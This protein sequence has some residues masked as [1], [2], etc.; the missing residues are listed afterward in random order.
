MTF[1]IRLLILTFFL[2]TLLFAGLSVV[3]QNGLNA[4]AV[5]KA[6]IYTDGWKH[7]MFSTLVLSE[8]GQAG[9]VEA[10]K[11]AFQQDST[12]YFTNH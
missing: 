8:T 10:L 4:I 5:E 12:M 2:L 3:R 11:Q 9:N 6:Q 7:G 1:G